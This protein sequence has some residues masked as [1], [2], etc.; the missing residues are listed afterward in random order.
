MSQNLDHGRGVEEVSETIG[1]ICA[2]YA[3]REISAETIRSW[4]QDPPSY[5]F[6]RIVGHE[7]LKQRLLKEVEYICLDNR[8]TQIG[9]RQVLDYTL[10]GLPGT[11]KTSLVKAFAGELD[12]H[13]FKLMWLRGSDISCCYVGVMEKMVATAFAVAQEMA[14]CLIVVEELECL[15]GDR[16]GSVEGLQRRLSVAFLEAYHR[17][18]YAEKPLIFIGITDYPGEVEGALMGHCHSIKLSLPDEAFRAE[19]FARLFREVDK[20]GFAP[21]AGF[22]P[23]DMAALTEDYSYRDLNHLWDSLRRQLL[24]N[25]LGEYTVLDANGLPDLETTEAAVKNAMKAGKIR[26]TRALFAQVQAETPP[27]EKTG[28]KQALESFEKQF[29]L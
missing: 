3:S 22:T 17:F 16:G 1:E 21:E 19:Y 11:G 14:P 18:R 20:T 4:F 23:E 7:K 12:K 9:I 24:R 26:I 2:R 5:G 15:C 27:S 29:V 10:Y 25:A 13:G 8:V 6:E 28:S